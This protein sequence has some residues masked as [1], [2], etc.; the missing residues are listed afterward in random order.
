MPVNLYGLWTAF[1]FIASAMAFTAL[2]AA[3]GQRNLAAAAMATVTGL[4]M[5]A[6]MA[7]W[8][9]MCLMAQFEISLALIFYLRNQRCGNAWLLFAQGAALT[10]LALWTH[11]YLFAMVSPIVLATIAQSVSNRTLRGTSAT[12]LLSALVAVLGAIIVLSGHLQSSSELGANG[13]GIYSMNLLSPFLPQHSGLFTPFRNMLIDATG[14]Q[15]EGF[16]YLGAG[17]TA[18]STDDFATATDNVACWF[19][20]AYLVE[21]SIC[22]FHDFCVVQHHIFRVHK[23]ASLAAARTRAATGFDV[24]LDRAFF[25]AGNVCARSVG[26]CGAHTGLWPLWRLALVPG[27]AF[28]VD[29]QRT[30]ASNAGDQHSRARKTAP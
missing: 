25:L 26:D 6:L 29:R 9:H 10:W 11:P 4:C 17:D 28:T 19:F 3:L 16:S 24:P 15:Y 12:L 21:R 2:V 5:P 23:V 13:V 8:G 7:R 18:A 27:N 30:T 20:P 22:W 1:C 14:G